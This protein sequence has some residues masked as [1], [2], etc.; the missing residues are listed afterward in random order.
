M[1]EN[2]NSFNNTILVV[3]IIP[4][5]L[6]LISLIANWY[7]GKGGK[8]RVVIL[9]V[10][11]SLFLIFLYVLVPRNP[12]DTIPTP[13]PRTPTTSH[14]L[15]TLTPSPTPRNTSHVSI[16][17]TPKPAAPAP[18]TIFKVVNCQKYVSL[19]PIANARSTKS[20]AVLYPDFDVEYLS[21]DKN[22]FYCV[23]YGNKQGFVLAAYLAPKD[24]AVTFLSSEYDWKFNHTDLTVQGITIKQDGM[25][26]VKNKLGDPIPT[27]NE[28]DKLIWDYRNLRFEFD[29]RT[30]KVKRIEV[31]AKGV[32]GPRGIVVG[33]H[34]SEALS[35]FPMYDPSVLKGSTSQDLILY[36]DS[37]ESLSGSYGVVKNSLDTDGNGRIV[38]Q[39]GLSNWFEI[40]IINS[41]VTSFVVYVK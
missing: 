40:E 21:T 24:S 37:R 6:A 13:T 35:T 16:S 11:V 25:N 26:E 3:L 18:G 29:N 31:Y 33:M 27:S 36:S 14:L 23:K 20:T 39:N 22:G 41:F 7:G 38:F 28:A 15:I 1:A 30:S 8:S 4:F 9:I 5:V 19:R 12:S 32:E 2:P 17:P 10:L 34:I